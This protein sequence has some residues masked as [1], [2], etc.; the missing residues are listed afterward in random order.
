MGTNWNRRGFFWTSGSTSSLC[1][2]TNTGTGCPGRRWILLPWKYS[3][4]TWA[5]S[6]ATGSRYPCL[7]RRVGQGGWPEGPSSLHHSGDPPALPVRD[8]V[9][10]SEMKKLSWALEKWVLIEEKCFS[11]CL[12]FSSSCSIF[13]CH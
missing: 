9:E 2:W 6:W 5:W 7:S 13:I 12:C 11:F 4:D 10:E 3:E 8:K 1:E